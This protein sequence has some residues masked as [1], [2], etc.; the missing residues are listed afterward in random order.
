[1]EFIVIFFSTPKEIHATALSILSPAHKLQ[2]PFHSALYNLR[3]WK[4]V[5]KETNKQD[6]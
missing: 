6:I 4:T 1:M 3:S 5:V 2:Q